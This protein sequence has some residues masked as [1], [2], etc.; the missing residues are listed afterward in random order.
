MKLH[1]GAN[2][3]VSFFVGAS[4]SEFLQDAREGIVDGCLVHLVHWNHGICPFAKRK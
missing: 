3:L 4:W 2:I 1:A